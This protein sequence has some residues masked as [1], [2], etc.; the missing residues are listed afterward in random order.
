M[1]VQLYSPKEVVPMKLLSC[2]KG[3]LNLEK[4]LFEKSDSPGPIHCK[5]KF[6]RSQ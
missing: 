5:I 2:V 6:A 1:N 4:D 3:T